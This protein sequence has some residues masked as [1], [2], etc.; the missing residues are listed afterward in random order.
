MQ[1]DNPSA[2][3]EIYV[4]LNLRFK[5]GTSQSVQDVIAPVIPLTRQEPGNI[6][7]YFMKVKGS[8]D[9][10]VVFEH[11]KDAAAL[12]THWKQPYMPKV[13]ELFQTAMATPFSDE[14]HAK[15]LE[16]FSA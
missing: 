12:E 10:Y 16:P 7:F 15:Y 3:A 1:N 5:P 4:T 13:F 2:A 6:G 8:D 11:W 9:E 14:E